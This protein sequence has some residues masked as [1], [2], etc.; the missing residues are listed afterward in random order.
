LCD[1]YWVVLFK[2][3]PN[4]IPLLIHS[5][6][7]DDCSNSTSAVQPS[8][9][10]DVKFLTWRVLNSTCVGISNNRVSL[11]FFPVDHDFA[12]WQHYSAEFLNNAIKRTWSGQTA[13]V[14]ILCYSKVLKNTNVN[15]IKAEANGWFFIYTSVYIFFFLLGLCKLSIFYFQVL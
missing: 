1:L 3:R 7:N 10:V 11:K 5:M 12:I 2:S 9:D 13:F 4:V 8:Q 14:T 15:S 6:N